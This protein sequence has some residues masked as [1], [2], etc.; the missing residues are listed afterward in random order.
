MASTAGLQS[1]HLV[2][3][4][5]S[6]ALVEDLEHYG[7]YAID[8]YEN[9]EWSAWCH[10]CTG[11]G[12]PPRASI[13]HVKAGHVTGRQCLPT[14]P[15]KQLALARRH[16]FKMHSQKAASLPGKRRRVL[17]PDSAAVRFGLQHETLVYAD[18]QGRGV[19]TLSS[20]YE[21]A[22]F[23]AP[24]DAEPATPLSQSSLGGSPPSH[25]SLSVSSG[26][27]CCALSSSPTISTLSSHSV[28]VMVSKDGPPPSLSALAPRQGLGLWFYRERQWPIARGSSL[29][30]LHISYNIGELRA[31]GVPKA[32]TDLVCKLVHNILLSFRDSPAA[33]ADVVTPTSTQLLEK[34][35]GVRQPSDFEFG[36]CRTCGLRF[37]H[38]KPVPTPGMELTQLLQETCPTCG[39]TMYKVCTFFFRQ[40]LLLS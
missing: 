17:K 32:A 27:R 10:A 18:V 24:P 33:L 11:E 37:P 5:F 23:T 30:V 28:D 20:A 34:V 6:D 31:R 8:V 9:G 25:R 3:E 4:P 21:P 14:R 13:S 22:T 36:W 40:V 19:P 39:T 26:S 12:C 15:C 7:F 29:S 1:S 16:F 35:L 2:S 38:S